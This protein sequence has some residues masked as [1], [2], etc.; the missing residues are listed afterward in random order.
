MFPF[1]RKLRIV[2]IG[3][4]QSGCYLARVRRPLFELLKRGHR[5]SLQSWG[6]VPIK[7][8]IVIFNNLL[9]APL[10][11]MINDLKKHKIKIVYDCDDAQDVHPDHLTN[12]AQIKRSM[13]SYDFLL[14]NADLITTTTPTLAAHLAERTDKPIKVLPNCLIPEEFPERWECPKLRIGLAGSL[15]HAK[16]LLHILDE[17]IALRKK[18]DFDFV[19]FGFNTKSFEEWLERC[20]GTALYP[21]SLGL[22]VKLK[23]LNFICKAAVPA[24]DYAA[25][26]AGLSLDIGLCPLDDSLFNRNKSC[27]KFYEYAMVGT[28][29][30]ASDVLPFSEEPVTKMDQLERLIADKDFREAETE[31]QRAWV[32]ENRD[33]TK[34][35]VLWEE[36]FYNLIK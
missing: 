36:A 26:L 34:K 21:I 24:K 11:E 22:K 29:A 16:D 30:V 25:T 28:C 13:A 6:G 23:K 5:I 35:Y 32:M 18:Y 3:D 31:R 33:M 15:S 20:K 1:K 17:I 27:I 2:S 19:L 9:E 8:D 7:T 4:L 14:K 12:T 10:E